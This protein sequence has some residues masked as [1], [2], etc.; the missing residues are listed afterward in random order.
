MVSMSEFIFFSLSCVFQDTKGA[1][2]KLELWAYSLVST[3]RSHWMQLMFRN[4]WIE[5]NTHEYPA[6][7]QMFCVIISWLPFSLSVFFLPKWRP[8][9][10]KDNRKNDGRFQGER[11]PDFLSQ[12]YIVV[13]FLTDISSFNSFRTQ[14]P[15]LCQLQREET[16]YVGGL[17]FL[18]V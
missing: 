1:F 9:V 16:R 10:L 14:Q 6:F 2:A 13:T 11:I 5:L 7:S 17:G 15:N 4:L 18:S 12:K 3:N 8:S